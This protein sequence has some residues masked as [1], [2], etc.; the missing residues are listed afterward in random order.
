MKLVKYMLCIGSLLL[1]GQINAGVN[2]LFPDDEAY[3]VVVEVPATPVGGSAAIMKKI[4]Y[5][6]EAST[7]KV[8]GKVYLLVYV[9]E[10]GDVDDVKVVKGIGSGCDEAAVSAVKRTKFSPGMEKGAAVKT[11]VSMPIQFKL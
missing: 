3:A 8:E 10:K 2:N 5:P 7:K 6:I 11:K 9:N 4:S 1:A